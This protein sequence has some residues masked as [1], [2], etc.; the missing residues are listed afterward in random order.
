MNKTKKILIIFAI[1]FALGDI[2]WGVYDIV[3]WFTLPS[4][5]RTVVFYLVFSFIEVAMSIAVVVLLTMSIWGN[6]K[7]FKARYGL[8]MTALMLSLILN[9]FSLST[10]FLI[11]SMFTSNWVWVHEDKVQAAPNVEIINETKEEKIAKLRE[12]KEKGE[13]SQEEFEKQIMDLL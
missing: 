10:I 4:S 1:V 5:D 8:Y 11:A 13:I 7:L 2:A 12:K 6:G 9:L 3:N